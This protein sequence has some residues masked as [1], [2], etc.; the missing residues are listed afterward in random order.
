MVWD[1]ENGLGKYKTRGKRP[2]AE[3]IQI[4][5]HVCRWLLGYLYLGRDELNKCSLKYEPT[6]F[7]LNINVK[8]GIKQK[9]MLIFQII[10]LC[11]VS[12]RYT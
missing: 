9:C 1:R 6:V 12:I 8:V 7:N 3:F 11:D 10:F 5:P 4:L 2:L